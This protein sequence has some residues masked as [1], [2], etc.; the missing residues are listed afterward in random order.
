MKTAKILVTNILKDGKRLTIKLVAID[1]D[2][3]LLNSQQEITLLTKQAIAQALKQGVK[4]V[5]CSGRPLAGILPYARQL[6]IDGSQQYII[7]YNGGVI[8]TATGQL[9]QEHMLTAADFEPLS[10]F[11]AQHQVHFNVLDNQSHVYT[12][13]H[14]VNFYTLMQASE[15]QAGITIL[16]PS[17]LPIQFPLAKAVLTG[18]KKQI[19]QIEPLLGAEFGQKHSI[20]RS[21]PIM[22]EVAH[23]LATKGR[24]LRDLAE[25]LDFALDEVMAIGDELNDY[26]MLQTA[27]TAVV[28]KNGNPKMK[29]IADYVTE[30]NDHDGVA[31]ALEKFVL[32]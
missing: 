20:V 22:L 2:A 7:T 27:G 16:D 15:M 17:D 14:E 4:I 30:D 8:Q 11:S 5:L 31:Q 12:L 29:A 21:M 32:R 18:E 9:I 19:D 13:D 3:T 23:S 10:Q 24:A 1:M 25:E 26:T 28:M 6:G